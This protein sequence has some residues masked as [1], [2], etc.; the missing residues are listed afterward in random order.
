MTQNVREIFEATLRDEPPPVDIVAGAV[1][2]A[3]LK[4]RTRR[5]RRIAVAASP[6]ALLLVAVGAYAVRPGTDSSTGGGGS[7]PP[8]AEPPHP[9]PIFPPVAESKPVDPTPEVHKAA[10][11]MC[12]KDWSAALAPV[13]T[14]MMPETQQQAVDMCVMTGETLMTLMPGATVTLPDA[15]DVSMSAGPGEQWVVKT[16][17]GRTQ[18]GIKYLWPDSSYEKKH[19]GPFDE[20]QPNP[21]DNPPATYVSGP[22]GTPFLMKDQ[23]AG[24]NRFCAQSRPAPQFYGALTMD[25]TANTVAYSVVNHDYGRYL[26][27]TAAV[28]IPVATE[29]TEGSYAEVNGQYIVSGKNEP[30][31]MTPAQFGDVLLDPRFNDYLVRYENYVL[32][33]ATADS[34]VVSGSKPVR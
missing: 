13:S 11:Q 1:E 18:I 16:P 14:N 3:R 5:R 29:P 30:P 21:V 25:Q 15:P 12:G 23:T 31:A 8:A 33:H 10:L 17:A 19:Y 22:D 32:T 7:R 4:R 2:G 28:S 6:L 24:H 27:G 20:C 26:I 34:F 9:R